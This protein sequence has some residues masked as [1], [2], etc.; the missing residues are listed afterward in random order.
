M[1]SNK[2]NLEETSTGNILLILGIVFLVYGS[3]LL[4]GIP[5]Y[6]NYTGLEPQ[7]NISIAHSDHFQNTI[8]KLNFI[9]NSDTQTLSI[10]YN[11]LPNDKNGF[12]AITLPYEGEL[13]LNKE[14]WYLEQLSSGE[15]VIFTNITCSSSCTAEEDEFIFRIADKLDSYTIPN[16]SIQLPFSNGI[17]NEVVNKIH[18]IANGTSYRI[19]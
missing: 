19:G 17:S 1:A 5:I 8:T 11:I 6:E 13:E 18:E 12:L 16:H 9:I 2:F 15:T 14:K 7:E 3:I 4:W 10:Y